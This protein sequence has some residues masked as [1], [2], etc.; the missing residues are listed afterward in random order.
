MSA[1]RDKD[2]CT[3]CAGLAAELFCQRF[4]LPVGAEKLEPENKLK[5]LIC[6]YSVLE[7]QETPCTA[8][9][10]E[11]IA[12]LDPED[13]TGFRHKQELAAKRSKIEE[14]LVKMEGTPELTKKCDELLATVEPELKLDII[15][16]KADN[17]MLLSE[18]K[19]DLQKACDTLTADLKGVDRDKSDPK[20][21]EAC[22]SGIK[23][24]L[25]HADEVLQEA[26]Q[27][28]EIIKAIREHQQ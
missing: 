27:M 8:S 20:L 2:V 16:M 22:E 3:G 15:A 18:T 14:M 10:V 12:K 5:A 13:K 7:E 21:Y 11:E 17:L 9:L 19:E 24:W 23:T 25:E 1:G 26:K 28:R 6:F 4:C